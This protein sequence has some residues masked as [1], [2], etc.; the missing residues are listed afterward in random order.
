M[1]QLEQTW[2]TEQTQP[3]TELSYW[4]NVICENLLELQ[5]DS[6][7]QADFYGHIVKRT[8][9]PLKANFISVSQQRV[10]RNRQG[11]RRAQD[12]IFHLIHLRRG[13]Q[14][15][16]HGGRSL[17]LEPGDCVL[18]DCLSGFKFDFPEGVEALVLEI[19]RD[20]VQGWLPAPEEATGRI[21]GRNPGWGATLSSALGNLTPAS[22]AEIGV[23]HAAVAEQIAVLLALATAPAAPSLT[24]HKRSLLKRISETLR[25]RCHEPELDPSA[26]ASSLGLSRRYI[27]VLLAAAGTTFSHELYDY[28]LQR[29]QRLLRDRRYDGV[30][31]AEIAWNCGFS[32][33]SHFTRR[34]RQCF[35]VAP[36]AY[37]SA[38]AVFTPASA[39]VSFAIRKLS[40]AAGTPA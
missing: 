9:G 1:A 35:G 31:I 14:F 28:R 34:F 29:A 13:I 32:E 5:I 36:T 30:G 21:F 26:V 2:S 18:V 24:T 12:A 33:P 23:P 25:E 7:R 4:K 20:W 17:K 16:E 3:G 19:R 6:A 10:W 15:V 8:L 39:K 27:H 11:S 37:R 40:T 22:L 38:Q